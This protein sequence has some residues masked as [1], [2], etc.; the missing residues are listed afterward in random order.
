MCKNDQ[1]KIKE[2][3][4]N[5]KKKFEELNFKFHNNSIIKST[6]DMRNDNNNEIIRMFR[7]LLII[8]I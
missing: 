2:I 6:N 7:I 1:K 5:L 8:I 3:N 4:D